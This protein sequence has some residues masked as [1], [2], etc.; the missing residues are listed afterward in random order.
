[1]SIISILELA[2]VAHLPKAKRLIESVVLIEGYKEAQVEFG[3]VAGEEAAKQS[4]DQFRYLVN[5]NQVQGN[6]RN[7]DYWRKQGWDQ[8]SAFVQD[9]SLERSKT[10]EKRSKLQGRSVTL[11]EDPNWLVVV[12]VDKDASCFHGKNTAWCTTKPF[13]RFFELYFYQDNV[14]LIYFL[15]KETGDKWAIAVHQAKIRGDDIIEL[16]DRND[17]LITARQ[18]QQ[19]TGFDPEDYIERVAGEDVTSATKVTRG[20]YQAARARIQ[21]LRPFTN[22]PAGTNV[23]AIQ[24]D[25][26]LTKNLT[27]IVEFCAN[28]SHQ[29]WPKIEPMMLEEPDYAVTYANQVIRGPWPELEEKLLANEE[30]WMYAIDYYIGRARKSRWPELEKKIWNDANLM[31]RYAVALGNSWPTEVEARLFRDGSRKDV[32]DYRD[33][34]DSE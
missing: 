3:S 25:L 4:I 6:E 28:A 9:R 17:L 23:N 27:A 19:Q 21:K 12:P 11:H 7:I 1:M 20:E 26:W 33:E 31:L 16:F 8:F 22:L 13:A 2:G 18:F 14:D 30:E 29:R 34:F 10:Q 32:E 15:R 5:R 24:R